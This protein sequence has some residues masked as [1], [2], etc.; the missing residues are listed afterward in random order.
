MAGLSGEG[1]AETPGPGSRSPIKGQLVALEE[2]GTVVGAEGGLVL[3]LAADRILHLAV[4]IEQALLAWP[5]LGPAAPEHSEEPVAPLTE[6][7][8]EEGVQLLP[9][10]RERGVPCVRRGSGAGACQRGR[11]PWGAACSRARAGE[12]PDE[13]RQ[14][15]HCHEPG[16]K[17]GWRKAQR[18][19]WETKGAAATRPAAQPACGRRIWVQCLYH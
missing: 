18:T 8:G 13:D 17:H 3:A 10:E 16:G 14:R 2:V 15:A 7:G 19:G 4:G 9:A 6:V 11:G 12:A 5:G 1:T